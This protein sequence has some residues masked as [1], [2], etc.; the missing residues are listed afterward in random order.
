MARLRRIL[1][2]EAVADGHAWSADRRTDGAYR[3][4]RAF[5]LPPNRRRAA[6]D[7]AAELRFHLA[8]CEDDLVAAGWT[9]ADA[10][11]EASRRFGDPDAVAAECLTIEGERQARVA[12]RDRLGALAQDVVHAAR[13]LARAPAFTVTAVLTL[14]LALGATTAMFSVVDAVLLRALPLPAPERVMA[15]D[16]SVG[17]E[18]RGGSPGLLA[19]WEGAR[20]FAAIGAATGRDG[21]LVGGT[22]GDPDGAASAERLA[23]LAVSGRYAAVLGVRPALGRTITADDDR[24]GAPPVVMLAHRLWRARFGADR[25]I[26]G[27]T[28]RL[29]GTAH[30][31]VGVLPPALD[32]LVEAGAFWVP[33]ALDPSQR[34]NFTPYVSLAGRLRPGVARDAAARELDALTARAGAAATIDGARQ[35]VRV[36]PLLRQLT[37]EVRLPLL[38]LLGAVAA[39]LVIGCANVATL[40]LA[41]SVGRGRELAVRAALGAGRG[42]L[43]RQLAV[44]HLVLGALACAV[45]LPVAWIGVRALLAIIP[46]GVPRLGA[47]GLDAR[48]V[49]FATGVGLASALASG[50]AGVWQH[51][52]V[53]VRGAMQSAGARGGTAR[54]AVRWRRL[55]VSVEA[56]LALV[57]LAGAGLLLRSASALGRVA[58]GYDATGVLTARIALPA[59]EYPDLA[60]AIATFEAVAD[61]AR[62][63]P[64]VAAA[65]LVSRVPLGGSMTGVDVAPAELAFT[66]ATRVNA[67]LRLTSAG[68]FRTMGIPL[69]AGRDLARSDGAGATAVVVVNATLARRLAGGAPLAS[70]V[71]RAIRSDNGAFADAGGRPRVMTIVG[72]VGDVRDGGPRAA[73]VPEFHAP[74]AQVGSEPWDY[75]IG[76]ELVLVARP[77]AGA[78]AALAPALARAV[79]S[80]DP[81]VPLHDVRTT[82][83][84]LAEALAIERF[85]T[86]LLLVLGAA[87]LA[88][89]ALGIHGVVALAAEQ[90]VREA[91]IRL[92]V[93][94]DARPCGG[95]AHAA[96][97]GAGARRAARR[98]CGRGR[99]RAGGRGAALRRHAARRG[100]RRRRRARARRRGRARVLGAGAPTGARR[101]RGGAPDGLTVR[102]TGGVEHGGRVP[103]CVPATVSRRRPRSVPP[104][105]GPARAARSPVAAREPNTPRRR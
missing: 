92:A 75:W 71:G 10:R 82:G 30:T 97:D 24:P 77:V 19:V 47:A 15:L 21:T 93:G 70:V 37:D 12:L 28:V 59:R 39:V 22:T 43:V 32:A 52:R 68:Y 89:A 80:V 95:A 3:G 35:T 26:V 34:T 74:L 17:G 99:H 29:D 69:L 11:A 20:A 1:G 25:A 53:D 62:R 49:L 5:R 104:A 96:G 40:A 33:L 27:R 45:A 103:T 90:R 36:A 2:R 13:T 60:R 67:A 101:P 44:E 50:L 102:R 88:L 57:L 87:G 100:Q 54:S 81:F 61:A 84:R 51:A 91:A 78:P 73:V 31:V 94:G 83:E 8:A 105:L 9:P 38:L 7:V 98:R 56:A 58:P 63:T 14:G 4:P 23:G 64:G 66:R 42:R 46:A 72:V 85:S 16:P 76:R 79:A 55:L 48:A 41:R 18:R 65:A 6:H 86:W